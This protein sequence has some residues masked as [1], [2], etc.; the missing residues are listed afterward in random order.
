MIGILGA[1]DIE[2]EGL[3]SAADLC[4]K[5][6][7]AYTFY[8]G[9]IGGSE[10]A[11]AKC[12]IGKVNAA[13]GCQVLISEFAPELV[14]NTGVAGSL[15]PSLAIGD[16]VIAE[17]VCQHDFDTTAL[18]EEPGLLPGLNTVQIPSDKKAAAR[19]CDIAEKFGIKHLLAPIA[20]GDCFVAD[21]AKKRFIVDTFGAAAAEMEGGAIGQVCAVN[22]VPFAV[23]RALSDSADE[24]ACD[25]YP[26]FCRLAAERSVKILLEFLK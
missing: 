1:M 20:S 24:G 2:I 4:E 14:I 17:S 12:G 16:I 25:D 10:V 9:K 21:A 7:G 5:H 8:T 3:R 15:A 23:L 26:S 22:N 13:M 11:V 6:I 18:G 19:L